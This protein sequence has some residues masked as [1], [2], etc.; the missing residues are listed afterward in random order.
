MKKE[1]GVIGCVRRCGIIAIDIMAGVGSETLNNV[2]IESETT[3]FNIGARKIWD[4]SKQVRPFVGLGLAFIT[5]ELKTEVGGLTISADDSGTGYWLGGGVYWT[6]KHFNIGLELKYS[7][8]KLTIGNV[9]CDGGGGHA[10]LLLGYH[11]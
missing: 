5:A 4:N 10:G 9:D 8:A 6:I 3:E 2:D 11:W 1:D 7:S